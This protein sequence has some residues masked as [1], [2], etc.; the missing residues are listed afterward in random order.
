MG[1]LPVGLSMMAALNSGIDY[2]MHPS[3]AMKYGLV[4][5][6]SITTSIPLYFWATK[7]TIPF[8]RRL[9]VYTAFE[10]LE[11]RFDVRVRILGA[12][13]YILWRVGWMAT[14]MYVP[15]LAISTVTGDRLS[16]TAMIIVLGCVVTLYTMLG[17]IKAVIW[18][19]ALQFCIMVS[20]LLVTVAIVIVSVP[21]GLAEIWRAGHVAGK[22]SW[23]ITLP[24]TADT[25]LVDRVMLFLREPITITGLI[26]STTLARMTIYT[27]D[28]VMVQRIQTTTS[29]RASRQAF[30][31][32][33]ISSAFWTSGLIFVGFALFAYFQHH[34]MPGDLPPDRMF[35]HFI[36]QTFP[37]GLTG[38]VIAA[39][40]AASLS[41]TDSAINACSA[42]AVVDFYNRLIRGPVSG[43][44]DAVTT[45]GDSATTPDEESAEEQRRQI[46]VSRVASLAFGMAGTALAA[47]VGRLGDLIEICNKVVNAFTGPLFGIFVLG[48]FFVRVRA[49]GV[50]VGGL[51]GTL[52]TIYIAFFTPLS[53]LWPSVFGLASTLLTGCASCALG[54]PPASGQNRWTFW[55]VRR[56]F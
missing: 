45:T 3:A 22:T 4:L 53:F 10:Y 13:I 55:H 41:S 26:V 12:G 8:Y 7:I 6:L 16:L 11:R 20:G 14:A 40:L 39:I 21:G 25:G 28:Q 56:G 24:I 19:D 30:L 54:G 44:P 9:Q 51:V 17:G 23:I 27:G 33:L 1:W 42:V 47:N 2:L 49:T 29:V 36:S 32:D 5:L 18:T 37:A 35:P 46:W 38:L 52:T 48:M 43:S 34:S 50:L 31:V 15:C